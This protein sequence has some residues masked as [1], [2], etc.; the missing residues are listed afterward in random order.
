VGRPLSRPVFRAAPVRVRVPASSANLGPGFDA[1]GLAL[2]RY[3]DVAVR[4]AETGLNV[5]I[6]GEGADRLPRTRRHL[7]VKAC[8]AAFDRLGGRPGGLDVVCANRIPHARGLGSS[9]AAIVA[10]ILAARALTPGGAER[11]DDPAVLGLAAEIEGHPDNV[12]ACLYGGLTLAYRVAGGSVEAIR[13]EIARELAPVAFVPNS[14]SSTAGARARLPNSV[15]HTD[16]THNAG[17]A[18]L[19]V[20][21]LQRRPALLLTATEDRL[22]QTYR[23]PAMPGAAQL[24]GRLRVAGIA[25]VLSGAGPTVLALTTAD[26]RAEAASMARRGWTAVPLDVDRQGGRVEPLDPVE[27][28]VE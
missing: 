11:L 9:A 18:A 20:A 21:A 6:A 12:A 27:G 2:A 26:Q 7:V 22:H 16:A 4:A 15:P 3:D 10:G 14:R 8:L 19:L 13:L 1:L 23:S 24:L 28:R 5:E 17:R 25:A